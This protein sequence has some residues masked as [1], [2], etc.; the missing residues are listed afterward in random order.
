MRLKVN[1]YRQ[2]VDSVRVIRKPKNVTAKSRANQKKR[3]AAA[4]VTASSSEEEES[5]SEE[6]SSSE[7][8]EVTSSTNKGKHGDVNSSTTESIPDGK[9]AI[10]NLERINQELSS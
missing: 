6:E 8:E 3:K 2:G 1:S 9:R 7:E 5:A 10:T 4:L